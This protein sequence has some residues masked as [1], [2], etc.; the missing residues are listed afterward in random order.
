MEKRCY[1]C[2]TVKATTDFSKDNRKKDGLCVE[3]IGNLEKS[4]KLIF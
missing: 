3:Y 4:D 1:K 2:E